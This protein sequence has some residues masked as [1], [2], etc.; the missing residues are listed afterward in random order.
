MVSSA[1]CAKTFQSQ[2]SL[3]SSTA[4]QSLH[5]IILQRHAQFSTAFSK[6]C[7]FPTCNICIS[8]FFRFVLLFIYFTEKSSKI[9]QYTEEKDGA[10]LPRTTPKSAHHPWFLNTPIAFRFMIT[11]FGKFVEYRIWSLQYAINQSINQRSLDYVKISLF[12]L[13][14]K[15]LFLLASSSQSGILVSQWLQEIFR[16]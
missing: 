15:K 6:W 5:F 8:R 4:F 11:I 13:W 2:K 12:D 3:H 1:E 10:R 14:L 16:G 9:I 7:F